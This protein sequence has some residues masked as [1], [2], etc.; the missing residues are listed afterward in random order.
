MDNYLDS[1]GVLPSHLLSGNDSAE[2]IAGFNKTYRNYPLRLG[3][4]DKI[5][6]ITDINNFTKL[7]T[8]YDILVF[9]QNEDRGNTIITYKNCISSDSL[10]SVADFLDKNLRYKTENT[11][12]GGI[13]N[14]VNQNGATVLLLCLDGVSEKAVIIGALPH[15]D[16]ASTLLNSD[17]YLEGEYN[18]VNIKVNTDGSTALTFQGPTNSD[19]DTTT[20][21][22]NTVFQIKTDGSFE[23]NH[24]TITIS[25][26]KSGVLNITTT[27]D[28]N[29]TVGGNT[30]IQTTGTA[31]IIA[32]G[33]TTV[34]GSSINLGQN[35]FE[36]VIKGT[37]FRN[38]Y[39]NHTHIGD[40]GFP[41]SAP[42]EIM[43]PA[44]SKHVFT[45]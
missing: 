6:P 26:N 39:N 38:I 17:P 2:R 35:A 16:R 21:N 23:F 7:S 13:L 14:T 45:E 4:V 28:A 8:E 1:G 3:I 15:P 42:N 12:P 29:I 44:L 11:N 22:G 32:Q 19:G 24:S 34:D 5:Y 31:N 33:L 41:T 30:N 10:G 20:T 40:L 43:D 18:G 25:A 27:S 36:S 37:T 9:E